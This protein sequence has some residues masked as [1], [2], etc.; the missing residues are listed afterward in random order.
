MIATSIDP[1]C[2]SWS[3]RLA[4]TGCAQALVLIQ[5]RQLVCIRVATRND[6]IH[7]EGLATDFDTA[8]RACRNIHAAS[9]PRIALQQGKMNAARTAS[10]CERRKFAYR[11]S[12]YVA[13]PE[14]LVPGIARM[15][16]ASDISW[17]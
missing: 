13:V 7:S 15:W 12:L 17:K 11:R 9:S 4:M 5:A 6:V 3:R 16:R 10:R 2:G 1:S 14:G 8:L